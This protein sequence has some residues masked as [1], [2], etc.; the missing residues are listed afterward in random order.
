MW[1][2]AQ[3]RVATLQIV[4]GEAVL[5]YIYPCQ[6]CEMWLFLEEKATWLQWFQGQ[7]LE[8]RFGGRD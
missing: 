5:Q 1:L 7:Q 4:T 6:L 3:M 2:N 8:N